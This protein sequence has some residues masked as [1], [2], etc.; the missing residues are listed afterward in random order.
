MV[1]H[2][3]K[4]INKPMKYIIANKYL[5]LYDTIFAALISSCLQLLYKLS[6]KIKNST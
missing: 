6:R 2:E 1:E 3:F 5:I 4:P